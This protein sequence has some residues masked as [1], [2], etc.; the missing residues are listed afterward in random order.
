V[1]GDGEQGGA[2]CKTEKKWRPKARANPASTATLRQPYEVPEELEPDEKHSP[3]GVADLA[4]AGFL[5]DALGE[6][7]GDLGA[8]IALDFPRDI[9]RVEVLEFIERDLIFPKPLPVA[10]VHLEEGLVAAHAIDAPAR[11]MLERVGEGVIPGR[12]DRAVFGPGG[13]AEV[14][15]SDTVL[16]DEANA[17]LGALAGLVEEAE[18]LLV[19]LPVPPGILDVLECFLLDLIGQLLKGGEGLARGGRPVAEVF[20]DWEPEL[21][22]AGEDFQPGRSNQLPAQKAP[23]AGELVVK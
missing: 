2:D 23:T 8:E 3:P 10:L 14:I 4:L 18:V 21:A 22:D 1:A 16:V 6:V 20:L 5:E 9:V 19:V 17:G 12:P 7:V 15:E 11:G 13:D